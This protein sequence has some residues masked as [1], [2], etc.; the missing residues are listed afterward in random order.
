M[1][2]GGAGDDGSGV[3]DGGVPGGGGSGAARGKRGADASAASG[4]RGR[5]HEV[6]RRLH[7]G[8]TWARIA[9]DQHEDYAAETAQ[10]IRT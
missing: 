2:S 5:V 9:G 8:M 10:N 6:G 4:V 7:K 1:G 3:G